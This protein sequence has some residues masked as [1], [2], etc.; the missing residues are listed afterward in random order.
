MNNSYNWCEH[1]ANKI[2]NLL[3]ENNVEAYIWH[4]ATTNSIYIR[5]KDNR[6]GSIRI[7]DHEGR[8]K[9]KYKFNLRSDLHLSKAKWQKDGDLWR[10]FAPINQYKE[11]VAQIINRA[12]QVSTWEE[13]KYSYNISK[14]K[15]I[16]NIINDN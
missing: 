3:K 14:F 7:A 8:D 6:I 15:Q 16:Q 12:K 9:L 4:K 5:F 2:I 11:M 1:Y 13:T 10:Y